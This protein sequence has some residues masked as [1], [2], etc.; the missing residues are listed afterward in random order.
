MKKSLIALILLLII[1]SFAAAQGVD[2][3]KEHYSKKDHRIQMRDGVTLFTSVYTPRD[4]TKLYPILMVRTPYTIAPYGED[5][6]PQSLGPNDTFARDG[7]IFVFQDVRGQFLSEG[8][9]DNMRAYI[10]NKKKIKDVDETTDTY[11][12]IEWLVKNLKFNNG[13]V[14]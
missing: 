7:Y 10:P 4:T 5:Q 3:I 2:W 12:T 6:Y 14:G 8:Q 13:N 1:N 11:D 9:F